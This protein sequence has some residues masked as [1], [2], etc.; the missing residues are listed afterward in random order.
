M[1]VALL[2][3]TLIVSAVLGIGCW[4]AL[5]FG[6]DGADLEAVFLIGM[7]VASIVFLG[8]GTLLVLAVLR[9]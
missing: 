9:T 1:R 7:V 5:I 6:A 3:A 2:S 8:S 4:F